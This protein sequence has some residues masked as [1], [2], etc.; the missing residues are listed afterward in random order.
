METALVELNSL[1]NIAK[2]KKKISYEEFLELC[3]EDIWAEWVNGEVFIMT[4]PVTITHQKNAM[5]IMNILHNYV[6]F[7]NL[8]EI[9]FIPFLMKLENSA[10]MPDIIHIHSNHL[11]N[12]KEFY[13][14]GPADVAI[15]IMLKESIIRD[16]GDKFIEYES[17]RVTEYWLI[18]P[19]RKQAEFYRI[20]DDNC[21]HPVPLDAEG[22]YHSEV[23]PG[24]WL[25]V[26]WLW[27]EPLPP[28]WEIRKELNLP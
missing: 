8:G 18:D 1:E 20:G 27:Q 21:Y 24:F 7:H 14:D 6:E 28:V 10:R 2:A 11:Q 23:I 16:R 5:F 4:E 12:L 13:L 22:K 25:K 26:S 3:D 9:L 19:M 15:E 17:G